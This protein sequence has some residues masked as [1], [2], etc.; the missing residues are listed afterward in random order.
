MIY[1]DKDSLREINDAFKII[2][3]VITLLTTLLILIP[4]IVDRDKIL[5]NTPVCISMSKYNVE[6][7]LCGMTRA[8]IE[9]SNGNFVKAYSLNKGSPFIY[10]AFLSNSLIFILNSMYYLISKNRITIINDS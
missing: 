10:I 5:N 4:F 6:C 3:M 7:A 8:F 1:W 9:I 2:W